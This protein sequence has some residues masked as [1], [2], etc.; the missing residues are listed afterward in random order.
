MSS[1]GTWNIVDGG[2]TGIGIAVQANRWY[3]TLVTRKGNKF[4]FYIDG[5]LINIITSNL[6]I[7]KRTTELFIGSKSDKGETFKGYISDMR[8]IK[9]KSFHPPASYF[10]VP[11]KKTTNNVI[12][13]SASSV[14]LLTLQDNNIINTS[15][16]SNVL[17]SVG[18]LTYEPTSVL[19]P[20][21]SAL[22]NIINSSLNTISAVMDIDSNFRTNKVKLDEAVTFYRSAT[23]TGY[24]DSNYIYEF[25]N[26]T[27]TT[28]Y[29]LV[30]IP[31]K[32][33]INEVSVYSDVPTSLE[34]NIL[35]CVKGILNFPD[36]TVNLI[37]TSAGA[38][39]LTLSNENKKT[40]NI[41]NQWNK[42]L[43]DDTTIKIELKSN[44]TAK[45]VTVVI[46]TTKLT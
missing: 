13:L 34:V 28:V 35:S 5:V 9:N 44:T 37:D 25:N 29:G 6:T 21:L 1:N 38:A 24:N 12:E 10:I 14:T 41:L 8:F 40:D 4:Y 33:K 19:T 43:D 2:T 26:A 23:E 31:N 3:H 15:I 30:V 27:N 22:G 16:K 36:T 11:T 39:P 17:S 32:C 18:T 45:D 46:N 20:R 7:A 42:I